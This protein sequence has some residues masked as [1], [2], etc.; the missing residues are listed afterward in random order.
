MK[1][2]GISLIA[3]MDR[4]RVIGIN[5]SLPWSL[6]ADMKHFKRLTWGK[7]VLMGRKTFESIGRPLPG[8]INIVLSTGKSYKGS[9][10][11]VVRSIDE[12]LELASGH[13]EVMV[14]GGASVYEQCLPYADKLYLTLVN[15]AFKGDTRF[16]ERSSGDW[17]VNEQVDHEA[18]AKNAFG[19]SFVTLCRTGLQKRDAV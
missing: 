6:P 3:A 11:D 7:P 18:D 14:I 16:P 9:G 5:N 10:I 12:A 8:R 1:T 17:E 4:H 2:T 19:Y 13:T 15:G